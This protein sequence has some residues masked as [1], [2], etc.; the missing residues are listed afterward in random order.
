MFGLL[1]SYHGDGVGADQTEM[2]MGSSESGHEKPTDAHLRERPLRA[3]LGDDE[4][5]SHVLT[6]R[7]VGVART[8]DDT[9]KI[10]PGEEYG[11][12]AA[13]TDRRVLLLVGDPVGRAEGDYVASLPYADIA[14]ATAV[15]A[16]LTAELELET[17]AGVTWTFTARE[18]DID[19]VAAFLT[20][21]CDVWGEVTVALDALEDHCEAMADAVAG[22]DWTAFDERLTDA[23]DALAAARDGA[24]DAPI[25]G[26]SERVE[27]LATDL[28]RLVRNRH[29]THG[30]ELVSEA[31]RHLEDRQY[32]QSYERVEAARERFRDALDAVAD[33]DVDGDPAQSGLAAA[34]ELLGTLAERPLAAARERYDRVDGG[35]D[36]SDRVA[37]LEE[38]FDRYRVLAGLV[39]TD[40]PFEGDEA[41]VREEVEGVIADLIDARLECARERRATGNWEWEAD[42]DEAAYEL[43]SAAR[44]DFDRAV[45]LAAE[46]PP[47]DAEAI[48]TERDRLAERLD[49]LEIRYEVKQAN[50]KLAE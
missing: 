1:H 18:A 47:G 43:L 5:L 24:T 37:A 31:E 16:T 26:I 27:R 49:P 25:D 3:Y 48:E 46:F 28:A 8:D 35:D 36:P 22:A 34:E 4:Q 33:A 6:N 39:A 45:E 14:D 30:E 23:E 13:M 7:R 40:G 19:E 2:G 15:T 10:E 38:T 20:E 50:E 17:T 41:T 12:V 21:A 11:A 29:V 42:N 32:R 9:T 44:D